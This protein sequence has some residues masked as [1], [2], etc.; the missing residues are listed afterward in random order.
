[1]FIPL[2]ENRKFFKFFHL[3]SLAIISILSILHAIRFH[4]GSHFEA[5]I[6]DSTLGK[7]IFLTVSI[8]LIILTLISKIKKVFIFILFLFT[9]S[10][11]GET[12]YR[13][14]FHLI[15]LSLIVNIFIK[16]EDILVSSKSKFI[17]NLSLFFFI[18]YISAYFTNLFFEYDEF[19]FWSNVKNQKSITELFIFVSDY[20]INHNIIYGLEF[21]TLGFFFSVLIE[22]HDYSHLKQTFTKVVSYIIILSPLF[23]LFQVKRIH[24][25]FYVN[26]NAFWD[27]S[28][29]HSSIF[30]D[31]NAHGIMSGILLLLLF[32]LFS[33]IYLQV[34]FG[35]LLVGCSMFSGSRTFFL[36]LIVYLIIIS[37]RILKNKT[38]K[39]ILLIYGSI[40]IS[41][42]LLLFFYKSNSIERLLKTFTPSTVNQMLESRFI[43]SSVAVKAFSD[44]SLSGLGL[45]RFYTNQERIAES[46]NIDLTKWRDNANNYYLHIAAEH[47]LIGLLPI[48]IALIFIFLLFKDENSLSK[49]KIL[50]ISILVSLLSGPHIFFLEV[51]AIFFLIILFVLYK[52]RYISLKIQTYL[53]IV[54][55]IFCIFSSKWFYQERKFDRGL[56]A[57]E[58]DSDN[59][60]YRWSVDKVIIYPDKTV[61]NLLIK[62]N[63]YSFLPEAKKNTFVKVSFFKNENHINDFL[64]EARNIN[65]IWTSV[66]L[67]HDTSKIM[68]DIPF[69]L[70]P[71]KIG[72]SSDN[73]NLGI[74]VK[75]N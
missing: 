63:L 66:L 54:C 41:L 17:L 5:A 71:S 70:S 42:I 6:Q 16:K 30:S 60:Y 10:L 65:D 24:P 20:F 43:Y 18:S 67:P 49:L 11:F 58:F 39:K 13:L 50:Y 47:G 57:L 31:P 21:Y 38:S 35:V 27:L 3:F 14:G 74:Q 1:M 44:N 53:L 9:A 28:E 69:T 52:S 19:L 75:L 2:V 68:L 4:N 51:R 25:L 33:K 32:F 23:L 59:S 48:I 7:Y 46:I 12:F 61:S 64:I 73:R 26:Q 55:I 15:V 72:L 37:Y 22:K 56:Y 34:F 8:L 45:G 36:F 40:F 62:N 29:R